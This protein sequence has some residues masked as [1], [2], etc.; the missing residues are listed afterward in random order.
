MSDNRK[1]VWPW[2][3]ALL[4][5][6][7]VLY[8]ASFGPACWISSRINSGQRF[9]TIAYRPLTWGLN[10]SHQSTLDRV[11]RGYASLGA[12]HNQW[13]WWRGDG[14]DPDQWIWEIMFLPTI[15]P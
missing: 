7:P 9:V 2:I 6:L 13:G 4:I 10:D 14:T 15:P 8:V 3:V 11:L 1:P 12:A 5:G